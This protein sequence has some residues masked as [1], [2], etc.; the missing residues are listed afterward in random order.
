MFGLF[1]LLGTVSA[2]PQFTKLSE[3]EA[4]PWAGRL[5]NDE[6][7]TKFIVSDKLKV[8]QCNI[9]T[10]Y[11]LEMLDAELDLKHSKE[12]IELNTTMAI[13]EQKVILRD[14]RI[15]ELSSLK[16]PPNPFWYA[17]A[18]LLFGSAVTIAITYSVNQ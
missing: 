8:E 9:Q 6:A 2:E 1:F 10:N 3:G 4:A 18:G 11:S 16:T 17:T 12:L 7:V 14:D 15:M 13:L 5:F